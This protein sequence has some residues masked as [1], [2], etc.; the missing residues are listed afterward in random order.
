MN[1]INQIRKELRLEINE[2]FRILGILGIT[3]IDFWFTEDRLLCDERDININTVLGAMLSEDVNITKAIWTP[4]RGEMVYS[5]YRERPYA[6]IESFPFDD[7]DILHMSLY[8]AGLIYPTEKMAKNN[9]SND[10]IKYEKYLKGLKNRYFN[11]RETVIVD[12]FKV[13][14][15][16][17]TLFGLCT[18]Q[19]FKINHRPGTFWFTDCNLKSDYEQNNIDSADIL[20]R[21]LTGE[22]EIIKPKWQPHTGQ[23][24]YS[25]FKYYPAGTINS[26]TF[27]ETNLQDI[28][29]YNEGVVYLTDRQALDHLEE[30]MNNYWKPMLE[31]GRSTSINE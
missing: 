10:P 16:I 2:L 11:Q 15:K 21:L 20:G 13:M 28:T 3:S 23:I 1:Y 4:K 6:C 5:S 12:C 19:R 24:V 9:V 31:K 14:E 27:C 17:P 26:F 8:A 7:K 30:D 18:G 29:L 25:A 22:Y